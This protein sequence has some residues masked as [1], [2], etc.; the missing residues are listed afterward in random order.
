LRA[1]RAAPGPIPG[2][3]APIIPHQ[4]DPTISDVERLREQY[5]GRLEIRARCQRGN[6][7]QRPRS[8][9]VSC[10]DRVLDKGVII[11]AF[12]SVSLVGFEVI[13]PGS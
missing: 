13:S 2:P 4:N 5:F 6:G 9:T 10:V 11:D 12:V 3:I 1:A 8:S 7:K